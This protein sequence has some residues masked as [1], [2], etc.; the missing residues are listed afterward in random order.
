MG[1]T[2]EALRAMGVRVY[3]EYE[4]DEMLEDMER[5]AI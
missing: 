4:V 2:A 1:V 5:D 3:S